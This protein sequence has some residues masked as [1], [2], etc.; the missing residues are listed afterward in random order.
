MKHTLINADV[1]KGLQK[2]PVQSVHTVVTSPPYWSLRDYGIEGQ[3][4]LEETPEA[5]I[6]KIVEVFREVRRVLRDD[7]TLWLNYGDCYTS[8][9]K[10]GHGSKIGWKQQTNRGSDGLRDAPRLPM[11]AGL[12]N[13]DLVGMPW[14]IALALQED[15]WYLRCDIV[16]NKPNPMPESVN[17]RPTRSHEYIFLMTKSPQYFYDA[18]AIRE[19]VSG[20]A[21]HRGDYKGD[22]PKTANPG[23][24]IKNNSSF[25]KACWGS[26]D[27]R[28]SSSSRNLQGHSGNLNSEGKPLCDKFSRNARSVWT[29]PTQPRPDAHF[30]TF[31]DELARRCILAGTSE[32]GCCPHCGTP[33]VRIV[34]T[35]GGTTGQGWH[36][37]S[38]DLQ[39]GQIAPPSSSFKDY[40]RYTEGWTS[41]CTCEKNTPI[42]CTVLDPFGGSGTVADIAREQN[43]SSILIEINPS[44]VEMQKQR[45]RA[46]EQ[47]D[48]GI[49][50]IEII[51]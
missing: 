32:Y 46:D 14:R 38:N 6:Q 34:K 25:T 51:T 4:G 35:E 36:D 5:H 24:R 22:L 28:V 42:P 2:L 31:P 12:K 43:R 18:E 15:G 44:Y 1:I 41:S 20:G 26:S 11:P 16:W 29:I 13:K 49:C 19:N 7:G 45:L 27:P 39:K 50:Q 30:A 47:L 23:K 3:I 48:T 8:G 17:D 10:T 40:R 21:H 9:N 33:W 37:H